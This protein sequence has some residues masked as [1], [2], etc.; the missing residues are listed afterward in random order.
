MPALAVRGLGKLL[1]ADCLHRVV[2][3]SEEIGVHLIVVDALN[4]AARDFYG[5]HFGFA[6]LADDPNHLYLPVKTARRVL[7]A[8]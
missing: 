7:A 2:R 5:R 6:A 1:V 8:P 4:A 3:L